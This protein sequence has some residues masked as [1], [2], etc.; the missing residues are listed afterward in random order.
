MKFI[1]VATI[2]MSVAA[3]VA[4]DTDII[5]YTCASSCEYF[6]VW[7]VLDVRSSDCMLTAAHRRSG[8]QNDRRS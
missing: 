3:M 4:A 7:L 6:A 2:L 8:V 5:G 1:S